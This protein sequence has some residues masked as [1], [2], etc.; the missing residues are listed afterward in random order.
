M[1]VIKRPLKCLYIHMPFCAQKCYYCGFVSFTD[2]YDQIENYINALIREIREG[3]SGY[4]DLKL[5]S[6]YIGGGTPSLVPVE[7]YERIF[8]EISQLIN[9]VR[10]C[11][12]TIEINPGTVNFEYLQKLRL[13]GINRLSIGVQSFNDRILGIINRKHT[14]QDA[15]E[16]ISMARDAGFHN[17]SIDLIHGLPEQTQEIWEETLNKAVNLDI[18]H[19]SAY[20]LKI[21]E[22]TKFAENL[23]P[24]LP[25][26]ELSAQMYLKTIDILKKY[27]FQHYEISNFA[28]P[29]YESRHNLSYWHNEEYF[30]FG[31]AAHGYVNGV[32]YS[33]S[34]DFGEYIGDPLKK[35]SV[36][37]VSRQEVIEE[38]IFLGLRLNEGINISRFKE[39]Y[40]VDLR[41][42]YNSI[43]NK[44]ID[45]GYMEMQE[46][47]LRLTDNG[48]LVSNAILAEFIA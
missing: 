24:N 40:G 20:G 31:L 13:L 15:V 8:N 10:D 34:C 22:G 33:N 41:E 28:I 29:G 42:E 7:Y 46:D 18:N 9:I 45:Y 14:S 17:I 3:L 32:R 23:P 25:E 19:I 1:K 6:I 37:K 38:G 43:I 36:H 47:N 11:E 26:E 35:A 4:S 21:E 48:I 27:N 39:E 44:Y 12:V 16:V 5:R 2:K 30:A